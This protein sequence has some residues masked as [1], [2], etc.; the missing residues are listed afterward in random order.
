MKTRDSGLLKALQM[1]NMNVPFFASICDV[2]SYL[3]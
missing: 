1:K 3:P 2:P